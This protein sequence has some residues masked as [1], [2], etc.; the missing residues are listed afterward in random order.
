MENI[1]L[2]LEKLR[3]IC[4]QKKNEVNDLYN[5]LVNS[6]LKRDMELL[7]KKYKEIIIVRPDFCKT[8][9]FK[10]YMDRN[11][12]DI[13][14]DRGEYFG[15]LFEIAFS[16]IDICLSD[17]YVD[18]ETN[19][20]YDVSEIGEVKDENAFEEIEKVIKRLDNSIEFLKNNSDFTKYKYYYECEHENVKCSDIFEVYNIVTS[21]KY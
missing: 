7:S 5:D 2:K 14:D 16:G 3:K 6:I 13:I 12:L 21:R 4:S 17:T 15:W 20:S 18:K 9:Y 1:C 10:Y 11:A 8:E 19:I